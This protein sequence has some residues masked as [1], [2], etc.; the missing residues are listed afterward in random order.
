MLQ[1][2]AECCSEL[3]CVA[4]CCSALQCVAVCCMCDT[5][6]LPQRSYCVVSHLEQL[7][8]K[9]KSDILSYYHIDSCASILAHRFLRIDSCTEW[10]D[11]EIHA[12][13]IVRL[14]P[15]GCEKFSR[16]TSLLTLLCYITIP[17]ILKKFSK[18]SSLL[19]LLCSITIK[20]I[21]ENAY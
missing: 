3:Q 5:P 10:P 2:V 18:D 1:C 13:I 19:T 4:V 15:K 7:L 21:F 14:L 12:S 16:D 11:G 9:V 8:H 17:F 20:M 6:V